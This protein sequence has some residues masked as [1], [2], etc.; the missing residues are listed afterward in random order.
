MRFSIRKRPPGRERP[1]DWVDLGGSDD[2]DEALRSFH[3][4]AEDHQPGAFLAL[5]DTT[6]GKMLIWVDPDIPIAE[7]DLLKAEADRLRG[8]FTCA[9]DPQLVGGACAA[10]HA[11]WIDRAGRYKAALED[12]I[13]AL[14]GFFTDIAG[15]L[16]PAALAIS[17]QS[18]EHARKALAKGE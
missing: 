18:I 14:D 9:H 12:V 4:H 7:R 13:Q 16:P 1:E 2:L 5:F 3:T 6:M 10:C 8:P 17:R 11:E 15:I